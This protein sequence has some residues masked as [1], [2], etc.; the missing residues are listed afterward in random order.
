MYKI[1]WFSTGRDEAAKELLTVVNNAIK[2]RELKAE[3]SFVF[4]NRE[5]GEAKKSDNFLELVKNYKIPL[6]TFSSKKFK[7]EMR[8][9]G[10]KNPE[11][12]EKWRREYDREIMKRL[13]K[14][15]VD[16]NVLAGYMLITSKELC[17]KYKMINLHPAK[18][19]GPKGTWQEVIWQ[20]IEKREEETGVMIH[21]VT[22][23]LDDGPP[24]TYCKFPIRG[25]D[26]ENLWND[27]ENKLKNKTLDEIICEEGENNPL[28]LEIRKRGVVRELPLLLQ[29]LKEFA[30]GKIKIENQ[31][32]FVDGKILKDGSDVSKEID[33]VKKIKKRT[34]VLH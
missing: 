2:N 32:V 4:C 12:L 15:I 1:G 16:I 20:L 6:I 3:I 5:E 21:L 31:R 11:I 34:L 7:P 13:D 10:K 33:K 23:I 19:F 14:Y 17:R 29:T 27:F 22:E 18:P 9:Q 24:I 8:K 25:R 30:E 28:F 26:F